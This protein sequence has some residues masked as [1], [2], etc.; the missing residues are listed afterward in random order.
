MII[1]I[2]IIKLR[3]IA[4]FCANDGQSGVELWVADGTEQGSK[5]V[6]GINTLEQGSDPEHLTQMNGFVFFI[7]ETGK[8]GR[9]LWKT[10][11]LTQQSKLVKNINPGKDIGPNNL[12][13]VGDTLFFTQRPR[14]AYISNYEDLEIWIS[15]G[16]LDT[17]HLVK[18]DP[19]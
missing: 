18:N 11:L 12:I 15:Q 3:T 2:Q 8:S 6:K 9:E 13:V 14:I 16:T 17:T 4:F 19:S 1:Q 10:D 7:A 5:R